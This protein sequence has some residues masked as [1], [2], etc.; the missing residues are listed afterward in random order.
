MLAA[1]EIDVD[2]F[3]RLL[4]LKLFKKSPNDEPKGALEDSEACD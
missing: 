1:Y 3:I 4:L 2:H